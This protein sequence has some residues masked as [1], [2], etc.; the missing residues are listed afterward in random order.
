MHYSMLW[1]P[2]SKSCQEQYA[3]QFAAQDAS[4]LA[5]RHWGLAAQRHI[6]LQTFVQL[7]DCTLTAVN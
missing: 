3:G 1:L 5:G 6:F 7:L 2:H 4:H